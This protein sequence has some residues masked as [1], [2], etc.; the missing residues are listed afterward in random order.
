MTQ[1]GA[2][3]VLSM[4]PVSVWEN[5]S[6]KKTVADVDAAARFLLEGW[7]SNYMDTA[8]HRSAKISALDALA[9]HVPI[10]AFRSAFIAAADE[11]DILAN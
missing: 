11:A 8:A 10:D 9:G 5:G 4:S 6:V 7:P 1:Q 3:P 2:S